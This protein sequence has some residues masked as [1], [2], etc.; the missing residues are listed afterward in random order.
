MNGSAALLREELPEPA[1]VHDAQLLT[2]AMR[3][4]NLG[5]EFERDTSSESGRTSFS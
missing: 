1:I 2:N 3:S 4:A 5:S